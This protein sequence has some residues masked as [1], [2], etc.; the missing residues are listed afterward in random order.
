MQTFLGDKAYKGELAINTPDK[1]TK[2]SE[3][4][5]LQLQD[6]KTISLLRIG[7][8]HAYWYI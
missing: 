7:V 4:T 5:D 1:K 2:N 8:E 6:N 3:L